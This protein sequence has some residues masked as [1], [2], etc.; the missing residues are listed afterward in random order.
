MN[1]P[2]VRNAWDPEMVHNLADTLLE[3]RQD[4]EV[5]AV[6]IT[7]AG[8]AFSAGGDIKVQKQFLDQPLDARLERATIGQWISRHITS[9]EKPVI[10]AVNGPAVGAACDMALACDIRIASENASFG[11]VFIRRGLMPDMGGMFFL[12]RLV[13]VAKAKE[14]I[15]TGDIIDARE[16]ERIGLVNKVVPADK[17]EIATMELARRLASGPTKAIGLAKKVINKSLSTDLETSLDYALQALTICYYTEDHAEATR[18][19]FEKREPRFKG[20]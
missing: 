3:V 11:E 2:E 17:L 19:F 13:G 16:A 8:K 6:V 4:E 10:A 14:L 9:M 12:P 5:R 1:R 18:A 20:R 15:F 7:G